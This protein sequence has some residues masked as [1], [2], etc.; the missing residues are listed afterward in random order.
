MW[1]KCVIRCCTTVYVTITILQNVVM[2]QS[3]NSISVQNITAIVSSGTLK[4]Y[5]MKVIFRARR[6]VTVQSADF[7]GT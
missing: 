4:W 5:E 6:D 7:Q 1:F 3:L 2:A